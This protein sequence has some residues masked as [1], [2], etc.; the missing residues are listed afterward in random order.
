[1]L[2]YDIYNQLVHI[3]QDSFHHGK[4]IQRRRLKV[5]K[6]LSNKKGSVI[7]E[8]Y[9]YNYDAHGN[10]TGK[11]DVK[12]TTSYTYDQL[13]RL[14]TVS[15]PGGKQT[16]YIF[17]PSGNRSSQSVTE[18]QTTTL[19]AYT[20]DPLNRLNNYTET[21]TAGS[22]GVTSIRTSQYIYDNNGNQLQSV[23]NQTTVIDANTT[24]APN[25]SLTQLGIDAEAGSGSVNTYDKYNQLVHIRQDTFIMEN[26]YN[27]EGLRVEKVVTQN[28]TATTSRYLYEYDKVVLEVNQSN[29]QTGFNVYG[30]N[31]IPDPRQ[32][33][34]DA[35]S[36]IY[37][38]SSA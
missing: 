18:A 13:N 37:Q 31:L 21:T 6:T 34:N 10:M 12:G 17:D 28:S 8:A 27:G 15:E 22:A 14:A 30:I 5:L 4:Q 20:Y 29:V 36:T 16:S 25:A 23:P 2:H 19:T 9:G 3:R 11:T 7:L 32:T 35:V 24:L 33:G 1:M 26:K 38:A